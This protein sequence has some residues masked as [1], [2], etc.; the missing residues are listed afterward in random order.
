MRYV[1][2][3]FVGFAFGFLFTTAPAQA[4]SLTDTT[5]LSV[6]AIY[7]LGVRHGTVL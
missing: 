6:A 5:Y 2:L 7:R 4:D 3:L 1:H